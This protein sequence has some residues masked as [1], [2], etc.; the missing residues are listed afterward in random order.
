MTSAPVWYLLKVVG[1]IGGFLGVIVWR[2]KRC[3]STALASNREK[4]PLRVRGSAISSLTVLN[5][6]LRFLSVGTALWKK[7]I[8]TDGLHVGGLS[9]RF[10]PMK[11][12]CGFDYPASG[13]RSKVSVVEAPH[14]ST[15]HGG[16]HSLRRVQV[17]LAAGP[18]GEPVLGRFLIAYG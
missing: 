10:G 2:R 1:S 16:A 8:N 7:K 13:L 5:K 12:L 11:P 14:G 4:H 18:V 6:L 9:F 3:S 17:P 15:S